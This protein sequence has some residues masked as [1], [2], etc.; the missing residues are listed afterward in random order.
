MAR[1][2]LLAGCLN[3]SAWG[4]AGFDPAAGSGAEGL[5]DDLLLDAQLAQPAASPPMAG[6]RF[7]DPE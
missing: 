3:Y 4:C 7:T 1:C 2:M 6:A 5:H